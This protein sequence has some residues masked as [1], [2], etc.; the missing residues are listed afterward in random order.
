ME[1]FYIAYY[2]TFRSGY[3]M[4]TGGGNCIF[5]N[6]SRKKMSLAHKNLSDESRKNMSIAALN[7]PA[8][9]DETK[10]KIQRKLKNKKRP[11][12]VGFKISQAKIGFKFTEESKQKM[13]L[14]HKGIKQSCTIC[15]H[16]G[17]EGGKNAMTRFHFDNCK[18]I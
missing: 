12:E 6:I 3:N 13:R 4:T 1:I 2:D 7:R 14:A 5:S 10:N 17:L 9:S 18:N 8:M 15:P 11:K 16:C